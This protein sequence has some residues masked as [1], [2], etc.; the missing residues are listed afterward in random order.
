MQ[1]ADVG[2]PQRQNTL[3]LE[4]FCNLDTARIGNAE[5]G[6]CAFCKP[7]LVSLFNADFSYVYSLRLYA[8]P[9]HL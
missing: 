5:W 4:L 9:S 7:V 3:G 1:C 2:A 8:C 6:L